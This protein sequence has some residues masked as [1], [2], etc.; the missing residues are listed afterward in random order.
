MKTLSFMTFSRNN[1]EQVLGLVRDV[2]DI[3][4]EIV[5]VD[6]SDKAGR[7]RLHAEKRKNRFD[8]LRIYYVVPLGFVETVRSYALTKCSCDW[9]CYLDADERLSDLLKKDIKTL[10]GTT[11]HQAFTTKRFEDVRATG[12]GASKYFTWQTRLFQRTKVHYRG[13]VDERPIIDGS[14]ARLDSE[15]YCINHIT[16][17]MMHHKNEYYVPKN[18]FARLELMSYRDLNTKMIEYVS[19]YKGVALDMA[20]C[21]LLGRFVSGILHFYEKLLFK[22]L[23]SELSSFDYFVFYA[24]K[25]VII[26]FK[27][28]AGLGNIFRIYRKLFE[29]HACKKE[30]DHQDMFALSRLLQSE[31]MVSLLGLDDNKRITELNR[32]YMDHG[33][34]GLELLMLL[35]KDAY[36]IR[37]SKLGVLFLSNALENFGGG[38]RWVLEIATRLKD[39]FRI[40]V[41]SIWSRTVEKR[42]SIE[43]L[44]KDFDFKGIG[45]YR[46]NSISMTSI[47]DKSD[48]FKLMIPLIA[49]LR[50]LRKSIKENDVVYALTFNPIYLFF[51]IRYAKR[52]KKRLIIGIHNPIFSKLFNNNSGVI[53]TLL[54]GMFIA[55]LKKIRYF[56]VLNEDDLHLVH[57]HI[58]S[59][60]AELIPVFIYRRET[61]LNLNTFI[62]RKDFIVLFVGRLE[63]SQKGID[64]LR[65]VVNSALA[66]NSNIKFHIVGGAG[67]GEEIVSALSKK[68][69]DNVERK[70]Y[71]SSNEIAEEFRRADLFISTSR[72]E[73]FPAAILDAQSHGIYTIA[74]NVKGANTIIKHGFQGKLIMPFNTDEFVSAVIEA[75]KKWARRTVYI[76]EREHISESIYA[77]YGEAKVLPRLAEMLEEK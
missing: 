70:S 77:R 24:I 52:Y 56:H 61:E 32:R 25:D 18:K 68:Y 47:F 38:E 6:S 8:K 66:I 30:A 51:V 14:T 72:Y 64:I 37:R 59:A 73:T 41:V 69:P 44:R 67:D 22:D 55:Q 16:E 45:L 23:D 20:R 17:L 39:R 74:F 36:A 42:V 29:M 35:L 75:H 12:K 40:T 31:G 76:K 10:I 9:V 3:A 11:Q 60:H 26:G 13:I 65:D 15:K 43:E 4:D 62:K 5:L 27:T 1:V 7:E 49:S 33:P 63:I 19:R 53:Q 34:K 50:T 57:A 21:T 46:L 28:G 48:R 58:P 2:Y 54:N 71:L